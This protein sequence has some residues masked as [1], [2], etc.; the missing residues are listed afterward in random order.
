MEKAVIIPA[1]LAQTEEEVA[2]KLLHAKEFA[3]EVQIDIV[4]GRFANPASWPF[5]GHDIS[6]D[7]KISPLPHTDVLRLEIDLMVDDPEEMLATWMATGATRILF[8]AESTLNMNAILERMKREYGYEKGFMSEAL[9]VGIAVSQATNLE[10]IEPYLPHIDYV[11]FMGI[12][13]I[14]VQGQPFSGD[15]L[16]TIRRF[17]E[18][19]PNM[20]VQVDGGITLEVAKQLLTLGVSRLVVGSALWG[21]G[22]PKE[23]YEE[24]VSLTEQYGIYE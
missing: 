20:E 18:A 7:G 1:I 17:K 22:D 21:A 19:H 4:D 10:L 9:S 13:R 16:A 6:K 12:K 15:V 3:K 5:A 14:G 8:H 23:R 2:Q 24:F 11:Q